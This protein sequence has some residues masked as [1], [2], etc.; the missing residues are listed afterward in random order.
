MG[1]RPRKA[2]ENQ[3]P[4]QPLEDNSLKLQGK[5]TPTS[6]ADVAAKRFKAQ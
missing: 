2:S 3:A 4:T 6:E 1:K 5:E